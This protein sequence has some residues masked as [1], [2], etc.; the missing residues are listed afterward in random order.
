M[1]KSYVLQKPE[2]TVALYG[3]SK[4]RVRSIP[5]KHGA[6]K[7][8]I[9][10]LKA[11]SN[12]THR[13]FTEMSA[14]KFG[15]WFSND[16]DLFADGTTLTESRSS[17]VVQTA[18]CNLLSLYERT[19][20][21]L[22]VSHVG[23]PAL[24][25]RNK[26]GEPIINMVTKAYQQLVFGVKNPEVEAYITG[27]VCSKHFLHDRPEAKHLIE[28]FDQFGELAFTDRETGALDI[29]RIIIYQLLE[30]GVKE[31]KIETDGLCTKEEPW[32]TN[33]RDDTVSRNV[34]VFVL[35]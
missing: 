34:V 30:L 18:G 26:I 14:P 1:T 16:F 33:Y 28:P 31:Y 2:Y 3:P 35:H 10:L 27:G 7:N 5:V 12:E 11:A 4:E 32:L 6:N 9:C 25:P 20:H 29:Q 15:N 8:K 24:T 19:T 17:V 21:S 23:R 13:G 22:S